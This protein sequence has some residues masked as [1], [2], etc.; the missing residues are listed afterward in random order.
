ML[1]I[2]RSFAGVCLS[3]SEIT[4]ESADILIPLVKLGN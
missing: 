3:S 1:L 2:E 4:T